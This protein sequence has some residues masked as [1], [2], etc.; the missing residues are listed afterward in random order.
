MQNAQGRG[1]A[2]GRAAKPAQSQTV[3]EGSRPGVESA[4]VRHLVYITVLYF[5]KFYYGDSVVY[6]VVDSL[7]C[8]VI[9][10]NLYFFYS[11]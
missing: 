5:N 4:A 6:Y 2:R 8:Y 1:R 9:E 7:C 3:A 11:F 10:C